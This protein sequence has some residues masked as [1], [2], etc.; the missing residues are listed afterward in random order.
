MRARSEWTSFAMAVRSS[1]G[2]EG[3]PTITKSHAS[4]NF[5]WCR[6]KSSRKVLFKRFR[7][8]ELPTFRPILKP[9]RL[10][11][12]PFGLIMAWARNPANR[13]RFP[14]FRIT[15]NSS[16]V[17]NLCRA[18]DRIGFMPPNNSATAHGCTQALPPFAPTSLQYIAAAASG[19]AFPETKFPG[20]LDLGW[21]IGARHVLP[22]FEKNQIGNQKSANCQAYLGLTHVGK[23]LLAEQ[24]FIG[25]STSF[26]VVPFV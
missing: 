26:L 5:S 22:D 10:V 14:N 7:V 1:E 9:S 11:V 2:R 24:A 4:G 6:R 20:S 8:T 13:W 12:V 25:S 21:I 19:V 17:R 3:C 15:A 23:N 18:R 16:F